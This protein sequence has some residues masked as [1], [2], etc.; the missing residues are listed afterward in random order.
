M[1]LYI[2]K[3]T[4]IGP[5]GFRAYFVYFIISAP[6]LQNQTKQVSNPGFES[7]CHSQ[8]TAGSVAQILNTYYQS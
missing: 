1:Q 6:I 3:Y 7:D 4:K 5:D 8:P 2:M